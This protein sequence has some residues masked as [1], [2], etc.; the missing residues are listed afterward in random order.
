MDFLS[1]SFTTSVSDREDG[2]CPG[3][4]TWGAIGG[5][6]G[7]GLVII[8]LA[9]KPISKAI[10]YLTQVPS[11]RFTSCFSDSLWT[12]ARVGL[13]SP[14][15]MGCFQAWFVDGSCS[16]V[17]VVVLLQRNFSHHA[18]RSI[19]SSQQQTPQ[20]V[21]GP[22]RDTLSMETRNLRDHFGVPLPPFKTILE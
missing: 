8:G 13:A 18:S 2:R 5:Q 21:S 9:K 19:P 11:N 12:I 22:D 14:R 10:S 3:R 1:L 15:K 16:T 6:R 17:S 4:A 20:P 7:V